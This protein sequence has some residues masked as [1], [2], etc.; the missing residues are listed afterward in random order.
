MSSAEEAS[1]PAAADAVAA[2]TTVLANFFTDSLFERLDGE[3]FRAAT[4]MWSES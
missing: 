2:T 4:M 1:P 3:C